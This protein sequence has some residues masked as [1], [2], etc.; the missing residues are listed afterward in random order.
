MRRLL[1]KSPCPN[2]QEVCVKEPTDLWVLCAT[3]SAPA[4]IASIG[5]ASENGKWGP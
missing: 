1:I 2:S 4:A 5:N 3:K